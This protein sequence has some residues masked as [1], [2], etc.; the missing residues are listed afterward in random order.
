MRSRVMLAWLEAGPALN[1]MITLEYLRNIRRCHRRIRRFE[2]RMM[3][4]VEELGAELD[5]HIFVEG[6][7]TATPSA[8]GDSIRAVGPSGPTRMA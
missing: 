6:D 5:I 7:R 8:I 3:E 1:A 2:L 4:E